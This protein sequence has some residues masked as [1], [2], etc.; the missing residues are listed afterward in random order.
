M[1]P[2][3]AFDFVSTILIMLSV[4]IQVGHKFG[5][6]WGLTA[7]SVLVVLS[8]ATNRFYK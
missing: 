2:L 3:I 5:F 6:S 1:K 8:P 4:S 7:F